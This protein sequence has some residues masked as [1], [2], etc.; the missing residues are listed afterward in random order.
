MMCHHPIEKLVLLES[1]TKGSLLPTDDCLIPT[2][3]VTNTYFYECR[4]CGCF[5]EGK[6]TK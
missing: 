1:T 6:F 5:L 2:G 4:D 3:D